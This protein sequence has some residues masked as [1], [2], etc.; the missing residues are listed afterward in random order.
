MLADFFGSCSDSTRRWFKLLFVVQTVYATPL[1]VHGASPMK[2][3]GLIAV[4]A[5]SRSA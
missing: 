4:C 5:Q 2:T 1:I 3:P